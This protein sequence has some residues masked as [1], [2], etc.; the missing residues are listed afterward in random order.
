MLTSENK[1]VKKAKQIAWFTTGGK[2][3]EI[4][5]NQCKLRNFEDRKKEKIGKRDGVTKNKITDLLKK[6]ANI[7]FAVIFIHFPISGI[8]NMRISDKFTT[9]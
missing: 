9:W 5:I 2:C 3:Q 6:R 4:R 1:K 8:P 7:K